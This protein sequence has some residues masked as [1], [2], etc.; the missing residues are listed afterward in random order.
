MKKKLKLSEDF[1]EKVRQYSGAEDSAKMAT[2]FEIGSHWETH[3]E[4]Y[5]MAIADNEG[6]D[7]PDYK[8]AHRTF[9]ES[10]AASVKAS[11]S[12]MYTHSR[13]YRNVIARGL[14]KEHEVFSYGQWESLLR[15]IKK[16]KGLV[17]LSELSK[18][19]EWMYE[20]SEAGYHSGEFPSTRDIDAE[21]RKNGH[22]QEWELLWANIVRNARKLLE[23]YEIGT[24]YVGVRTVAQDIIDLQEEIEG[25]KIDSKDTAS[26]ET[27]VAND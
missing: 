19:I 21:Y 7:K 18:R 26:L 11:V 4:A 3:S 15:N 25:E 17:P 22:K 5:T 24:G 8:K 16:E 14:D 13:I 23:C 2:A 1:I 12:A 20:E 27:E 9:I 10:I 6:L